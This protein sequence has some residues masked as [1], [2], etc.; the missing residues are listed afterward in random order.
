MLTQ[1][2][3]IGKV[4]SARLGEELGC[5]L[6]SCVSAVLWCPQRRLAVM[7][8]IL[9]PKSLRET[10]RA[11]PDT[12]FAQDSWNQMLAQLAGF[13]VH[14]S[15]C[16]AFIAGGGNVTGQDSDIGRQNI[17]SMKS[18]L[19]G[20]GVP[21]RASDTGG[22]YRRSVR[23]EPASGVFSVKRGASDFSSL[24]SHPRAGQGNRHD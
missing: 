2:V 8:H 22:P 18:L 9:L 7:N 14:A 17:A 15:A 16:M 21:I 3:D 4:K 24:Q 12:R 13:G 5:V 6:G 11:A 23:F 10:R 20:A 1:W 19:D